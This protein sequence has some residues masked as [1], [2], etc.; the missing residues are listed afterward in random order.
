MSLTILIIVFA[1]CVM[2]AEEAKAGAASGSP[3]VD[4]VSRR[5]MRSRKGAVEREQEGRRENRME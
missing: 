4:E 1:S 5:K 2:G 3:K